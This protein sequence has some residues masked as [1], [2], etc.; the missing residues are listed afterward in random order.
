MKLG[1]VLKITRPTSEK[2]EDR[3]E[4]TELMAGG[5]TMADLEASIEGYMES[6][7]GDTPKVIELKR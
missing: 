7:V 5:E 2:G 3:E 4:I 6:H 1:N